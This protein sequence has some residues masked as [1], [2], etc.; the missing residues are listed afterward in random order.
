M[1]LEGLS[2]VLCPQ[3]AQPTVPLAGLPVR[4]LCSL[5]GASSTKAVNSSS[6]SPR[7]SLPPSL[8]GA[9]I[10]ITERSASF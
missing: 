3:G 6:T 8:K 7:P 10:E 2:E 1:E 5:L 9:S 4:G